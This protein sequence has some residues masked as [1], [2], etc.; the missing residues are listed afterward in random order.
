MLVL[1][2]CD[3]RRHSALVKQPVS[4]LWSHQQPYMHTKQNLRTHTDAC[5]QARI[6]RQVLAG[7]TNHDGLLQVKVSQPLAASHLGQI[8]ALQQRTL[9][10]KP[11]ILQK[12]DR[13]AR[14]F[15]ERLLLIALAG[16]LGLMFW[17]VRRLEKAS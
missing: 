1:L 16:S 14:Y 10:Q 6:Q 8:I 4:A 13:L 5:Q 3:F 2:S 15:V 7:S 12:T 17:I 9:S 11:V